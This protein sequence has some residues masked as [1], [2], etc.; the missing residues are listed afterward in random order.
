[1]Y[2]Q[3]ITMNQNNNIPLTTPRATYNEPIAVGT[4]GKKNAI[5]NTQHRYQGKCNIL[6]N[7]YGLKY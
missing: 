3:A 5:V 4:V 6:R 1:T 2:L 7:S